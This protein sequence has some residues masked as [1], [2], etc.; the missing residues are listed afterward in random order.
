M[1][2]LQDMHSQEIEARVARLGALPEAP[3]AMPLQM[4]ERA[5]PG[6]FASLL[7][8]GAQAPKAGH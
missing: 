2:D 5:T 7:R 6:L 3:L 1:T 4:I 8:L